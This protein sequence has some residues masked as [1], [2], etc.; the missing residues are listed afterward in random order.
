[1]SA[2]LDSVT[3]RI[4]LSLGWLILLTVLLSAGNAITRYA[5]ALSSNAML[6]LQWYLF[7]AVFLLGGGYAL[8]HGAHVSIDVLS[9][10]VSRRSRAWI[11]LFGTLFFL[12]PMAML[13]L[14]LSWPVFLRALDTGEVSTNAGGLLLWPARLLVPMGFALLILQGLSELLKCVDELSSSRAKSMPP[15]TDAP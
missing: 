15:E 9:S 1:M 2:I 4:G 14:Y 5:F 3:E 13:V 6:E 7:S 12:L 10:R 11:D 8:R